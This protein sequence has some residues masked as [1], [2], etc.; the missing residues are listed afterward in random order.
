MHDRAFSAWQ[1]ESKFGLVARQDPPPRGPMALLLRRRG[2]PRERQ[3]HPF[4]AHRWRRRRRG[5]RR[6]AR[7]RQ[8]LRRR[9]RRVGSGRAAP[10]SNLCSAALVHAAKRALL[11]LPTAAPAGRR[12]G[13][14]LL[15]FRLAPTASSP[16]AGRLGQTRGEEK[17][18]RE[19]EGREM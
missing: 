2:A 19:E 13:A 16:A 12:R 18:E 11:C 5:N 14:A 6:R 1:D 15:L 4:R 7:I 10:K 8:R 3:V 17:R 9:K